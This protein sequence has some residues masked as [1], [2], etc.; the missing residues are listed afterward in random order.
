MSKII[1][2]YSAGGV[3]YSDGMV[4]VIK[5]IPENEV[6][7]PKGTIEDGE[8]AEDAATREVYE[9]TGYQTRI[10]ASLGTEYY[11]YHEDDNHY[12]K[13][14]HH[15]LMEL[16][17]KTT[18]PTPHREEGENFENLWL[19]VKEASDALTFEPSKKTLIK[20]MGV[21]NVIGA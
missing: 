1:Q 14:V 12:G 8:T 16:I 4:L 18:K 3:V 15:Y 6:I 19:P 10:I 17:D 11:E 5:V 13:T 7:F 21:I 9:E 20:A 2:K